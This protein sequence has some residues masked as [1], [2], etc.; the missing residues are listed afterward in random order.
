MWQL[1]QRKSRQRALA[2]ERVAEEVQRGQL[3]LWSLDGTGPITSRI[4]RCAF[5]GLPG[6]IFAILRD[7]TSCLFFTLFQMNSKKISVSSAFP[8]ELSVS[9][10]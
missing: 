9:P 5:V 6:A 4:L 1:V 7:G 3:E 2:L 10:L 8:P